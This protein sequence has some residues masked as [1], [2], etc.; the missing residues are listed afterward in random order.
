MAYELVL[1]PRAQHDFDEIVQYLAIDLASPQ[2]AGRFI[3]E[4]EKKAGLVCEN[5]CLYPL[6]RIPEISARG[7]RSMPVLRYVALYSARENLIVVA[8][9]FHQ[10]Q[11]YA[12][13]V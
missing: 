1:L 13:F 9:I 5:P 8:H 12:R 10:S 6:S 7:Y 4:F 2:A 11:D 3:D